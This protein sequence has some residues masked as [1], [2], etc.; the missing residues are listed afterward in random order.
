MKFISLILFLVLSSISYSQDQEEKEFNF[1]K[2]VLENIRDEIKS[3]KLLEH[4][5]KK[6]KKL[7][8]K[9]VQVKQ[10]EKARYNYPAKNHA[11]KFLSEYWLV[12]NAANL[13]WDFSHPDYGIEKTMESLLESVG[14]YGRK[15]KILVLNSPIIAHAAIPSDDEVLFLISLPFMRTLDL[16][17]PEISLLL[18]EDMVRL[19]LGHFETNLKVDMQW[20]G[21]NFMGKDTNLSSLEK[22]LKRYTEVLTEE[23]FNYKQQFETTKKMD[24]Y[25]KSSP[26]AWSNYL[27]LL[28]KIDTLTKKNALYKNYIKIYPSPELQVQWLSPKKRIP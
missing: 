23:G 17:K 9:K 10:L 26:L 5:I 11:W 25:L 7:Q 19:E 12:K 24:V 28:N 15:F 22:I 13:K 27:K 8:E 1:S 6:E 3:D 2:D 20:V 21:S 18:L 14:L 16:S 4:K